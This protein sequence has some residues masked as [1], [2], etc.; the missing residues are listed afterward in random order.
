MTKITAV[1]PTIAV[2]MDRLVV[3]IES[4]IDRKHIIMSARKKTIDHRNIQIRSGQERKKP[5]KTN[6]ITIQK[7]ISI[8]ALR[9]GSSNMSLSARKKIIKI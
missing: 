8:I 4:L 5:I 6:S 9:N 3:I 7:N 2:V 1:Y